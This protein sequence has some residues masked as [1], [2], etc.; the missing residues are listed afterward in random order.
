MTVLEKC[1]KLKNVN[2]TLHTQ[3]QTIALTEAES[4]ETDACFRKSSNDSASK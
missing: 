3:R 4:V 1:V 2:Q